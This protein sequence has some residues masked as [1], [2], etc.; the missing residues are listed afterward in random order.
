LLNFQL[1]YSP[2]DARRWYATSWSGVLNT[3]GV[4]MT[5]VS[6]IDGPYD[7]RLSDIDLR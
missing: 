6:A 4:T 1:Q 5:T 2:R 7:V 3:A